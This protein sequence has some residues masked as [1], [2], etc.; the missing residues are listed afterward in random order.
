M[1]RGRSALRPVAALVVAGA[2]GQSVLTFITRQ[3]GERSAP[4]LS[5]LSGP[6]PALGSSY[7]IEITPPGWAIPVAVAAALASGTFTWRLLRRR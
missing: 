6:G 1:L 2:L 5:T 3:W 4:Q 7:S